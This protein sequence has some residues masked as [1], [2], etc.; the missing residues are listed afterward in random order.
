MRRKKEAS[1]VKQTNKAKQHSTPKAVTFP[2]KN[3]LPRVGLEPTTLHTL[4]RVLFQL[5]YIFMYTYWCI[6]YTHTA[7]TLCRLI[8]VNLTISHSHTPTDLQ[9]WW[10]DEAV[11]GASPHQGVGGPHT[12]TAP[13]TAL[14]PVPQP[15]LPRRLLP[16]GQPQNEE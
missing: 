5:S 1:K 4:D 9:L 13:Q 3:E 2:R 12:T 15:A 14:G 6:C 16:P 10:G 8:C 7:C 11:A